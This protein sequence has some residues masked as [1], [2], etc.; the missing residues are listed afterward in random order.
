MY[1][2]KNQLDLLEKIYALAQTGIKYTRNPFDLDRY[3]T[4]LA[5]ATD[6]YS[7]LTGL[8]T[9][10]LKQ[11]FNNDLGYATPKFGVNGALFNDEGKLLLEHRT[12]DNLWGLPGGWVDVGED[13][14]SALK[15]EFIEEANL[16]VEPV[17]L[18]NFYTRL[19]GPFA[20]PHTSV[21]ALYFCQY[22]GGEIKKSIES[23]DI[24]YFDP[25]T[26]TNWHKDH[27]ELAK[28]AVAYFNKANE[29]PW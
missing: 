29:L 18:I 26:I 2:M 21:H 5:I 12:D 13:P 28:Q 1:R 10:V 3:Q 20:Q 11:R 25:D 4:L 7:E 9:E 15:R 27:G 22:V 14:V 24:N 19:P 17:E 16:T 8:D 6:E 23:F